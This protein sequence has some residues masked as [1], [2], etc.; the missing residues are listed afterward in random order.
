[1][2]CRVRLAWVSKSTISTFF[3][4][5]ANTAPM[6]ATEA[7]FPTPPLWLATAIIFAFINV[8]V[9]GYGCIY[10]T[11]VIIIIELSK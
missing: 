2:K 11:K 4:L 1:M 5:D 10:N 7:V 6:D 9:K 8:G 3:P